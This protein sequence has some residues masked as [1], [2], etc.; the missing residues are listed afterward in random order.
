VQPSGPDASEITPR[1][2]DPAG[3]VIGSTNDPTARS[4][5]LRL[6]GGAGQPSLAAM[7]EVPPRIDAA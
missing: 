2:R 6:R 4:S 7:K 5:S 1:F 3:N